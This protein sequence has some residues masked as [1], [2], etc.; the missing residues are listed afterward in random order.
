MIDE[1]GYRDCRP[2]ALA[3]IAGYLDLTVSGGRIRV[4]Q[5]R[6][7][8][9]SRNFRPEGGRDC[10]KVAGRAVRGSCRVV[11]AGHDSIVLAYMGP[12]PGRGT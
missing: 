9:L 3:V 7:V 11:A 6:P 10:G 5:N 2:S 8:L 1:A 4:T 12:A